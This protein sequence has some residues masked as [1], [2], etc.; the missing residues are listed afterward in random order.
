MGLNTF[1]A[2]N[3]IL[4]SEIND[5]FDILAEQ[6]FGDGSDGD[7][8]ISSNTTLTRDMYYN[9]LTINSGI[10]LN[11]GGYRIYIKGTLT[12]NGVIANN[13]NDASGDTIGNGAPS[14]SLLG[15]ANGGLAG[16][17][18]EGSYDYRGGSG[19]G[20]GGVIVIMVK[21]ISV[22]GTIQ[23]N[24]GNGGNWGSG[25]VTRNAQDGE[26]I[27]YGLIQAKG[28]SPASGPDIQRPAEDGGIITNISKISERNPFVAPLMINK[29]GNG[30]AGG[31]GGGGGGG[32]TSGG[33]IYGS[34]GGG[35]GGGTIVIFYNRLTTSGTIEVNGGDFGSSNLNEDFTE[36][37]VPSEDGKII[38]V[39]LLS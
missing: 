20:G 32:R 22:E 25:T 6:L 29:E 9:D 12:N 34:G 18:A 23:A 17:Y 27:D 13:G 16:S 15:G 2:G 31:A 10:T 11:T 14:G 21:N 1:V 8:I 28:G 3:D 26:N 37:E 35:G 7:V 38:K 30:I 39:Q 19:G 33:S 4:S 36:P 24:G 5:N